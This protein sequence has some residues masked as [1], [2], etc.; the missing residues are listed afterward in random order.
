LTAKKKSVDQAVDDIIKSQRQSDKP[1]VVILAGHNGSGK[2][3]LWYYKLADKLQIPLI[4]A[5][6]MMLS[7]LPEI[8]NERPL[9]RWAVRLR[10]N[11]EAWMKVAQQG[12]LWFVASAMGS[13]V[14]FAMETVF[15]HW[16]EKP[17]GG[18][19]SKIDLIRELQTSGY[20]VVLIF[21]GLA[22]KELS[23]L[24]VQSRV[25]DGGHDVKEAKLRER[26]PRTQQAIG[27][28]VEIADA[29]ILVDNSGPL[30]DAFQV[31]RV[32]ERTDVIFDI[33]Q[34]ETPAP[35]EA[36]REWLAVICPQKSSS[37]VKK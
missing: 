19:E 37:R 8:R 29:S 5:D 13:K 2:S 14:P 32:Q 7:I 31:V 15:S 11:D 27:M 3:T 21:V 34:R 28:A 10:D 25:D 22:N 35:S 23:I 1:L 17:E 36:I 20:Y 26:F 30:E 24:R 33:R 12:V 18:F 16:K 6:R 4:N 9:P